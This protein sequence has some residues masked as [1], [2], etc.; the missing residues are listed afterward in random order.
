[1]EVL[2]IDEWK[3][4]QQVSNASLYS[5][6][7]RSRQIGAE[8][9][10]CD[11]QTSL[12][13]CPDDL[14]PLVH[15]SDRQ[16]RLV[17]LSRQSLSLPIRAIASNVDVPAVDGAIVPLG[18]DDVVVC[19]QHAADD[20]EDYEEDAS[21]RVL[22]GSRRRPLTG[23]EWSAVVVG[24]GHRHGVRHAAAGRGVAHAHA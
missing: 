17:L 4:L 22:S 11:L 5:E 1:M 24:E 13:G 18:L 9:P 2:P 16:R 23:V 7:T 19:D 15:S 10:G 21:A 3:Y 20:G 6:N 12:C 8:P 14:D